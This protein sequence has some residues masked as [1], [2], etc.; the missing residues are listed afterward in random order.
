[1]DIGCLLS[2]VFSSS[3]ITTFQKKYYHLF[4]LC[5]NG[6][7]AYFKYLYCQR[8]YRNICN[9]YFKA[10][11]NAES[12]GGITGK[13]SAKKLIET[14]KL[15]LIYYRHAEY[16]SCIP[17]STIFCMSVAVFLR[18]EKLLCMF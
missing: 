1:M 5:S 7:G 15:R 3:R 4:V 18:Y 17:E 8:M 16:S 14:N 6:G 11:K 10:Y 13:L 12:A 2:A 9:R